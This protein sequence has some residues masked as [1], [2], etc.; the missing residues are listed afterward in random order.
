VVIDQVYRGRSGDT[1]VSEVSVFSDADFGDPVAR[2]IRGVT[3]GTIDREEAVRRLMRLEAADLPRLRSALPRTASPAAQEVVLRVLARRDA[4]R[5]APAL[6]KAVDTA[7]PGLRR[8]LLGALAG[9]GDA[10]VPVLQA[11]LG[12]ARRA[13]LAGD[14]VRALARVG[15]AK[16][17]RA[18]LARLG[19]GTRQ[20]R[21]ATVV[22]LL[23]VPEGVLRPALLESLESPG[24]GPV[25]QADLLLLADRAVR[26]LPGLGKA[27]VERLAAHFG[28]YQ[29]MEARIRL[30]DLAGR[31]ASP[32]LLGSLVRLAG[33][34]GDPI[35]RERA[36]RALAHY[37]SAAA[38]RAITSALRA[39]HPR[40]RR[41]A[42]LAW[43][44]TAERGALGQVA[45]LAERDSWPMVR[46]AALRALG[47]RCLRGSFATLYRVARRRGPR[48]LEPLRRVALVGLLGCHAP[49]GR[50]LLG[51]ILTDDHDRVSMRRLVIRI[52]GHRRDKGWLSY[53]I[54]FLDL[55]AHKVTR[56]RGSNEGLAADLAEALGHIGDPRAAPTLVLAAGVERLPGMRAAALSSLSHFCRVTG[57]RQAVRR[58]LVESRS[59][60]VLGA[61]QRTAR[62]CGYR[63]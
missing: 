15:T 4:L 27:V 16:A 14:V 63:H 49:A 46:E 61:A 56:A 45:D 57:V 28:A 31:L 55:L 43:G 54:E 50:K 2:T 21:G 58:A 51:A 59:R 42:A 13:R 5:S 60:L 47:R 19:H 30:L 40:V 29:G 25:W 9:L 6:A 17:V 11:L 1:A 38:L 20:V 52:L 12:R 53:L 8:V 44:H 39:P 3:A 41:G 32:R 34:H 62:R 48:R 18:L 23:G 7:A 10:G 36:L 35:L 33:G 22:A 24:R 26:H 37:R